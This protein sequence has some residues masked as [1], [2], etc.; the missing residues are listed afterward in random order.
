MELIHEMKVRYKD[1]YIIL[2]SPPLLGTADS[3]LL[4][5]FVDG[6]ILVVEYGRTQKDQI[7][8]A[9]ELLKEINVIGTVLNK[10]IIPKKQAYAY[11]YYT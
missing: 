4:S 7:E 1:R 9:L 10:A 6:V 2:D 11:G 3:L 5:R 8:K